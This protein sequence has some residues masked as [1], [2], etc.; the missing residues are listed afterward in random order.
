MV[1]ALRAE[2]AR[3]ILCRWLDAEQREERTPRPWLEKVAIGA[4]NPAA[5]SNDKMPFPAA[6]VVGSDARPRDFFDK[7]SKRF[8]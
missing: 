2:V 4:L 5:V 1:A 3:G 8:R 6:L 7:G